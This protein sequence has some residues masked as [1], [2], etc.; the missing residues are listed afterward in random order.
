MMAILD[1]TKRAWNGRGRIRQVRSCH[2]LPFQ[3]ILWNRYLP[4]E[5]VK[6]AKNSPP[7]ISEGGRLWQV[8]SSVR[9]VVPPRLRHAYHILDPPNRYFVQFWVSAAVLDVEE[10]VWTW[11]FRY[12]VFDVQHATR[13]FWHANMP[14]WSMLQGNSL[15][16]EIC[17]N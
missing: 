15:V 16:I 4:S 5:P 9:R 17:N 8:W 14:V 11:L 10:I 2:I 12:S 7:S 3:P 6:T 13:P 1:T